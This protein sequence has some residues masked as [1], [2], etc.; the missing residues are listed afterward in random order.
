[1]TFSTYSTSFLANIRRWEA[2]QRFHPDPKNCRIPSPLIPRIP[3][4]PLQ[5]S[6]SNAQSN[7]Q[8]ALDNLK[9]VSA[10]IR[11][12]FDTL[13]PMQ[14]REKAQR[15]EVSV[16][17]RLCFGDAG[18]SLESCSHNCSANARFHL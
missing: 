15:E 16:G 4:G 9:A 8:V 5:V 12:K 14:D 17:Y 18:A 10:E 2:I 1:M 3:G 7:T 6:K 11:S 13:R